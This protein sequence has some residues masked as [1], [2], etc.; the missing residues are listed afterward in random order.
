M[1]IIKG[2]NRKMKI[3]GIFVCMLLTVT[4]FLPVAGNIE[5]SKIKMEINKVGITIQPSQEW[6]MTFGGTDYDDGY[7]VQQTN[8]GGYIITGF[9]LSFGAGDW[10]VWLIK[11]DSVGIEEWNYT[12]GGTD[13][14]RGFSVQQTNDSGYIIAGCTYSFGAGNMDVWL[15][16]TDS[17]G[18]EEWN[19]TFGGTSEDW[20]YSVQQTNDSGYIIAGYT[21][22]FGAGCSDVWLIKTDSVGIEEWNYTFGGPDYDRGFSVQQTNDSGYIIAGYT[23]SYDEDDTGCDVWL[24]KTDFV[25]I[26]EWNYTFGGTGI[27]N[28]VDMGYSVQ[29]TDDGGYIITGD[30]EIWFVS[31]SDVLLIK[32]DY[33]GNEEWCYTFGGSYS[34]RGRSVQ[35][36]NDDGYIVAGWAFSFS[37]TDPDIWLIKTDSNG[38]ADWNYI[39]G[40]GENSGDWGY[41]IQQTNDGGYIIA[42][43]TMPEG[44]MSLGSS[45]LY[46]VEGTN[47]LLIKIAGENQPPNIP[48]TPYGPIWLNL[49]AEGIYNTSASDPD[50]DDVQYRFDWDSNGSHNY[51]D[52]T[53]F[54]P[55][56]TQVNL[57]HS[58][59]TGGTYVVKA[60]ARDEHYESSGWSD[61]LSVFVNSPPNTPIDPEPEDGATEV[62]IEADLS[63]SCSEPDGDNL[64]Y[65]VYFEADD[66]TPDEL[67]SNNQSESWYDP[68]TMEY[69][70][71]YYWQIVAWDEYG[72]STEGLVW[73]FTTGS[74]PNDPPN[75]PSN[76][77]PEDGATE[78]DIEADLSWDCDDP[79]GDSLT[80]DVYFDTVNPPV[81]KVSDDQVE[82]IF[83][84][85]TLEFGTTFYWQII[86]KDEHG[87][88]T[89]GL[90]WHFTTEE[91]NPPDAPIITGQKEG[92]IGKEYEYTFRAV[93][94]DGDDVRYNISWGDGDQEWT[95]Y[96]TQDTDVKVKHTFEDKGTYKIK[97]YAQDING[98]DGDWTTYEVT[99]PKNKAFIFYVNILM[100]LFEHFP[101][102]F[103]ILKCILGL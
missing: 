29:Q 34:D 90:V 56:G 91:N 54:V 65:D 14:D 82:T 18:I 86:A 68:G 1:R 79:D 51:S 62:D 46:T 27:P 33:Y 94:S 19:Y 61:G 45:T 20:G 42:G 55:S 48:A 24:I 7:S 66:P 3:I 52:W 10:D 5:N 53:D 75:L 40:F 102:T 39:F 32:T 85:G 81:D 73:D 100:W 13:Y 95:D 8:D 60:Q 35:Q 23:V 25:G 92:K 64:T 89:P 38:N 21:D 74:E 47:V 70:T 57:S 26:E 30:T 80:Y 31:M 78:V 101:N 9:T 36:T 99:R 84:P 88:S 67:V 11:T 37:I 71:H 28:K 77:S 76:P 12:F 4:T 50:G 69:G 15:I 103:P 93:D 72:L 63:W 22:S 49:N 58:W 43:A 98:A 6:N 96:Y 17:V 2:G 16:K 44:W 83:D 59:D 87:A 97:A 41:S